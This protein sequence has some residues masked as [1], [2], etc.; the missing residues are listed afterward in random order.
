MNTGAGRHSAFESGDD[1]ASIVALR[2]PY[3]PTAGRERST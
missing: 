1:L 3:W 2:A